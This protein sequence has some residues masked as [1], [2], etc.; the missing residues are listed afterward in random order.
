MQYDE[1]ATFNGT[2]STHAITVT[3]SSRSE[4]TIRLSKGSVID[5]SET[6]NVLTA[7]N[8]GDNVEQA[9][10][11]RFSFA[12]VGA[13]AYAAGVVIGPIV[14][15]TGDAGEG[16]RGAGSGLIAL[17][18]GLVVGWRF[19]RGITGPL[20]RLG[21]AMQRVREH[22]RYDVAIAET[23]DREVTST[24][25]TIGRFVDAAA[26][27]VLVRAE[28][29]DADSGLR[30]GQFLSA[31]ILASSARERAR[32]ARSTARSGS[33]SIAATAPANR[34]SRTRTP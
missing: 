34:R 29:D 24:V 18:V 7:Y 3:K 14:A 8:P 26:Q 33:A 11:E 16:L 6:L 2:S 28:T 5:N 20:R 9:L 19:Q 32:W 27:T 1:A 23:G 15:V 4:R 10:K 17:V 22:H 30:V 25:T 21:A 12:Y 13:I 31:R